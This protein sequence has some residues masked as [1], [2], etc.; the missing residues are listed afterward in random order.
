MLVVQLHMIWTGRTIWTE[1]Y[2]KQPKRNDHCTWTNITTVVGEIT[3]IVN[4]I[5]S[6]IAPCSSRLTLIFFLSGRCFSCCLLGACT[7]CLETGFQPGF[8]LFDRL[9]SPGL[10]NTKLFGFPPGCSFFDREDDSR[11]IFIRYHTM[12]AFGERNSNL[13]HWANVLKWFAVGM[14]RPT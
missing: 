11:K 13:P 9:G 1:F 3:H 5:K 6:L 8:S 12:T 14:V 4:R 7:A 2:R 10:Q